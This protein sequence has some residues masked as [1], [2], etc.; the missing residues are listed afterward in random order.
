MGRTQVESRVET[1]PYSW[2]A[3]PAVARGRARA[4][5][6]ALLAVRRAPR[7]ARRAGQHVPHAGRRAAGGRGPRPRRRAARL[8][9]RLPPPRHGPRERAADARHDPVPVPRLD[10]RARRQPARRAAQQGGAG[11]RHGLP[12]PRAGAGGHLGPV[13]VRQ[14]GHGRAGAR[15]RARRPARRS[16]PR[17]GSTWTRSAS[18]TAAPT[19]S[20]RTGRS[21]SRTTSSAT[22]ASSTTRAS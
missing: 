12:R 3:D 13:R 10:L 15:R 5:L 22:T 20:G 18:T 19:R 21:R 17:T 14:P 7:R 6:P 4:D 9:Q 1:L 8:P 11:L 16:W 2:Y